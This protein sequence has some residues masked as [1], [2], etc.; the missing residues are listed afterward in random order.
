MEIKLTLSKDVNA[1]ANFY[2]DKSKKLKNKVPGIDKIIVKTKQDIS[3][4]DLKKE[5]YLQKKEKNKLLSAHK[6]AEWFDKFRYTYTSSGFLMV[7]GKD[8][9][10]NEVL[11]KRHLEENDLVLHTELAG[12]PFG[13]IKNARDKISKE[14]LIEAGTMIAC[15][16]KQWK[17]GFGNAD[18]FWVYPEQ[19]SKTANSGEYIAK[20]AF[21]VRGTK[22]F[23]KNLNLRICLGVKKNELI[24]DEGEKHEIEDLFSGSEQAVRKACGARMVRVEP[25]QTNYKALNKEVRSRLK[26]HVEDLPKYIPNG[27]KILKK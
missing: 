7:F 13:V 9:G 11:L 19:V 3:E 27:S 2:F 22:N 15:F 5:E 20:G 1:N 17:R 12:S 10:S 8:S 26:M 14:D 4:F 21:M 24:T 18:A 23:L 16:S 25:G 6:R